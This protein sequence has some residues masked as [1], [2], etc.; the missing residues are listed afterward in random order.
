MAANEQEE[1]EFRLRAEKE[2]AAKTAPVEPA[3]RESVAARFK[4]IEPESWVD[5]AALKLDKTLTDTGKTLS[6]MGIPLP[7]QQDLVNFAG[8][9]STVG[10]A[11]KNAPRIKNTADEHSG[12]YTLGQ[13]ADPVMAATGTKLFQAV[14]NANK[15]KDAGRFVGNVVPGTVV[16]ATTSL[17]NA[18]RQAAEGNPGEAAQSVA[19]G[20]L[21]GG[22]IGALTAPVGW[23]ADKLLSGAKN[24]V[25]G[26]AGRVN[27]FLREELPDIAK[28]R[29]AVDSLR[30]FVVGEKPTVGMAARE[31]GSGKLAAMENQARGSSSQADNFLNRDAANREAR[32]EVL[33]RQLF[34][35]EPAEKFRADITKPLYAE[36]DQQ[37]VPI[38]DTLRQIFGGDMVSKVRGAASR[39]G[40][41]ME[42]NASVAGRPFNPREVP[43]QP[44]PRT[45][46]AFEGQL[47]NAGPKAATM[48]VNELQLLKSSL[49]DEINAFKKGLP[50]PTGLTGV[51]VKQLQEARRQLIEE[52]AR[53]SPVWNEARQ[54]FADKS[55]AVNQN[56]VMQYL[57]KA[58]R[59]PAA[60]E[61][62]AQW[63]AAM[64][65][66][67]KMFERATGMPRFA[68]PEQALESLSPLGRRDIQNI[69]KSLER[70]ADVKGNFT[71]PASSVGRIGNPIDTV[72][73]ST[74][75]YIDKA[76]SALR[77]GATILGKGMDH[78]SQD[79]LDAAMLDPKKFVQLLDTVPSSQRLPTLTKLWESATDPA[80][81]GVIQAQIQTLTGGN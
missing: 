66:L 24:M 16:G 28:V 50:S 76:I 70:E 11:F 21:M 71:A 6:R 59:S 27:D 5:R 47:E 60:K 61:G 51:N 74:P 40:G 55:Q 23:A 14:A 46:F 43:G 22:G 65:D 32:E 80:A 81:K 20:T 25:G 41:Q 4:N 72:V 58:L 57:Y 33:R 29:A 7:S 75:A 9:A 69:T 34:T 19:A 15:I 67:P 2:R 1:F 26:T 45:D 52:T 30:G 12:A 31:A 78:K 68:T 77:K 18:T 37:Q 54:Q 56:A 38:T 49:D 3:S 44:A 62:T 13:I 79:M 53:L 64:N 8:G 17:P 42:T 63:N 39:V 35:H 48:S 36:A 10:G 73:Q